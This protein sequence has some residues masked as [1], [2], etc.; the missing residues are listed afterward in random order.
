MGYESE[1]LVPI[2]DWGWGGRGGVKG[3]E[4]SGRG[5]EEH[6]NSHTRNKKTHARLRGY[7]RSRHMPTTKIKL[8]IHESHP[9]SP[10]YMRYN[11]RKVGDREGSVGGM[12]RPHGDRVGVGCGDIERPASAIERP[13]SAQRFT[14]RYG[15]YAKVYHNMT[16]MPGSDAVGQATSRPPKP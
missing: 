16:S 3:G 13:E 14:P 2:V 8:T 11:L 5:R 15:V 4:E 10:L 7:A 12:G 1:E 6:E 9:T